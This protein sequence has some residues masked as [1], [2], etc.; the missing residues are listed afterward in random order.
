MGTALLATAAL[1]GLAHSAMPDTGG[2]SLGST[3][4]IYDGGKSQATLTVINSAKNAPFLAQSWVD[5]YQPS[6]GKDDKITHVKAPFMVTPPLYRQDEGKNTLRIVRTGG[7]LPQDR[8][9]AFWLNVKAIPGTPKSLQGK[10]SVQ[11][12]YVMR[13]KM[14]YRPTGL[15]GEPSAACQALT[16]TRQGDRLIASNPTAYYVTFSSLALGD[17]EVKE[18]S[19]MVPPM[20]SAQYVLPQGASGSQVTFKALNDFGGLYPERTVHL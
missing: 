15:T 17:K 13:V 14:F 10:N 20:G 12:A 8:E 2:F 16:F 11:F 4:V 1:S 3:R 6:A 7:N 5:M 19:A 18:T 9:S